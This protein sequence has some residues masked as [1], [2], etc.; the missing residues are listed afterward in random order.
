MSRGKDPFDAWREWVDKAERQLN[1]TLN[2]LSQTAPYNQVS[3][4]MVEAVLSMQS[5]FNEATQRYF[6]TL[7]LPTRKDLISVAERLEAIERRL[8][9]IETAL[10][11]QDEATLQTEPAKPKR[12]KKAARP[13]VAKPAAKAAKKKTSKKKVAKKKATSATAKKSAAKKRTA[14]KKVTQRKVTKRKAARKASTK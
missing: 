12:T 7:N 3:G 13:P 8:I 2:D 5:T 11:A 9:S 10:R 14:K 1:S 6:S 4:K